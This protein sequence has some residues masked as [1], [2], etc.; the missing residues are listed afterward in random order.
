VPRALKA[1]E[2]AAR[3]DALLSEIEQV[4]SRL[5]AHPSPARAVEMSSLSAEV[6]RIDKRIAASE[7]RKARRNVA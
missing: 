5:D 2:L 4:M 6:D 7:R 3:R 1:D